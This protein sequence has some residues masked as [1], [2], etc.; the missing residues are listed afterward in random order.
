MLV[1]RYVHSQLF[2][3]YQATP[4][5]LD[6]FLH[7]YQ[8][9][10]MRHL[11][12]TSLAFFQQGEPRIAQLFAMEDQAFST[13]QYV[14]QIAGS[15]TAKA[16][17]GWVRTPYRAALE[18]KLPIRE[19]E[20]DQYGEHGVVGKLDRTW[21]IV[22]DETLMQQEGITLGASSQALT[23]RMEAAG[24]Q[25]LFLAQKQPKRLLAIMACGREISPE[26]KESVEALQQLDI[27]IQIM[28]T[29]KERIAQSVASQLGVKVALGG[30]SKE[31]KGLKMKEVAATMRAVG[32]VGESSL[33]A[34]LPVDSLTFTL[35]K[36]ATMASVTVPDLPTLVA[37]VKRARAI[38][39]KAQHLFFW[40]S[41]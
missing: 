26:A 22:G 40:R 10:R 29:E 41:I 13:K 3:S 8:V 11:V 20:I 4:R 2:R 24:Y 18:A 30:L 14:L 23:Q 28:T 32:F 27:A 34:F 16:Q 37:E 7:V 25:L 36:K 1:E 31:E 6:S 35:Q 21:F 39:N 9:A 15:L 5:Y 19:V 12:F 38:M 33:T 17:G